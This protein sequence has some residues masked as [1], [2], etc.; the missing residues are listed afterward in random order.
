[1][2]NVRKL[3]VA[4]CFSVFC[5]NMA[6]QFVFVSFAQMVGA[7]SPLVTLVLSKVISTKEY[8]ALAYFSMLP[9]CGGV[10]LCVKGE[11][12]YSSVGLA[13]LISS[14]VLRGVKSIMQGALLTSSDPAEKLDALSLLKHMSKYSIGILAAYA[15][16][17]GEIRQFLAN[18]EVQQPHVLLMVLLSGVIAF[19]L[20]LCNFLV[21]KYTS[22]VTLQVLG[23]IKVVLSIALSLVVFGNPLSTMSIMGCCLTLTGVALYQR[24]TSK[25]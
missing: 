15:I 12:N 5:G 10:M 6:L 7:A 18:E 17:N 14:S 3:S 9:M 13:L 23:N 21:T 19:A 4:F 16:V 24:G 8:S 1:M 2:S 11:L 22:A 20:N 25:R